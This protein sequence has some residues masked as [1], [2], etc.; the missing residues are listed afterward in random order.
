MGQRVF[1]NKPHQSAYIAR[2]T[3]LLV[4]VPEKVPSEQASL[5]YLAQLG[6]AALRQARYQPGEQVSVIGLGVIGL[7]TV[8][9][10][11]ILGAQVTAVANS[12]LR[13][14]AARRMGAHQALLAE[15]ISTDAPGT[16]DL[17]VLT[18]NSWP[19]YRLAVAMARTEGRVSILG[20]P[21][22]GQPP[23][24]FNPLDP[25]WFYGKQLSLIGAGYSPR[26]E[27]EPREL[28]FNLRRNLLY[29]L[30]RMADGALSLESI[31]SHR[32]PAER[33]QE[34][35]ELARRH[36]KNLLAAIFLW[37]QETET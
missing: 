19:A 30:E 27:C 26:L 4:P 22:R 10:A 24:A 2:W 31:I 20:F 18:A 14:E 35:Y 28:R 25:S 12:P 3:E 15:E 8:A 16:T 23:P 11:R 37:S 34:A 13:A 33:M 32:R 17:V 6:L 36:D 9:V 21:G 29:L 7:C 5:A 1:A